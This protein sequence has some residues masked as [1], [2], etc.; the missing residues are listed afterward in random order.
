MYSELLNHDNANDDHKTFMELRCA[1]YK[2]NTIAYQ[3]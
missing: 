1:N 2:N 3:I